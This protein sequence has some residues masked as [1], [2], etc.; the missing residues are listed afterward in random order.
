M[1]LNLEKRMWRERD[2]KNDKVWICF[3]VLFVVLKLEFNVEK[4]S[5]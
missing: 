5:W 1:L 3:N 4:L 2:N